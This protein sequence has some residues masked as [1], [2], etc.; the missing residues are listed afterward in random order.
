MGDPVGIQYRTVDCDIVM[1]TIVDQEAQGED[2]S[3]AGRQP[4]HSSGV[5]LAVRPGSDG[6][7]GFDSL[8]QAAPGR[9][10]QVGSLAQMYLGQ[11]GA[12]TMPFG[13][14]D[15]MLAALAAGELD[16]AAVTPLSIG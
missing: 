2:R 13:F 9:G 3:C 10:V 11:R 1:D 14:E 6:I 8:G 16:A 4:Y 7:T 15:E 12:R 5:A